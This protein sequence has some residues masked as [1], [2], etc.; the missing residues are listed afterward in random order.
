VTVLRLNVGFAFKSERASDITSA[1]ESKIERAV[2]ERHALPNAK[3]V[4]P[5][6]DKLRVK[7]PTRNLSIL[8]LRD[9]PNK[10]KEESKQTKVRKRNPKRIMIMK[11]RKT[12]PK[13]EKKLMRVKKVKLEN[14]LNTSVRSVF[15]DFIILFPFSSLIFGILHPY[16]SFMGLIYS[17]NGRLGS[18]NKNKVEFFEALSRTLAINSPRSPSSTRRGWRRTTF[19]SSRV[20]HPG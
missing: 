4:V 18:I 2:N 14:E 15:L 13:D 17:I 7:E 20:I 3:C 8:N 11:R 10:I 16:H 5:S 12:E 19:H 6:S 1:T 9:Q